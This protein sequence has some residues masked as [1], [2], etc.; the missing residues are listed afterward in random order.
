MPASA[1]GESGKDSVFV[2][3]GTNVLIRDGGITRVSS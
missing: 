1:A 2:V 3:G